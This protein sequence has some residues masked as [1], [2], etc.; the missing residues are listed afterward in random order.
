MKIIKSLFLAVAVFQAFGLTAQ[1][2]I[3]L[4]AGINLA[5]V[6][7]SPAFEIPDIELQ[8]IT[9][10]NFAAFAEFGLTDRFALQ[11][12][13]NFLQKGVEMKAKAIENQPDFKLKMVVN[14]LEVPV[15]GKFLFGSD[16]LKG[17]VL[18]GPSI[19]YAL[20]GKTTLTSDGMTEKEKIE[21]DKDYDADGVKDQRWDFSAVLGA[22]GALGAGPGNVI[23]DFRY[24]LDFTDFSK[25]KN[26]APAGYEKSYNR[27]L[28]IS[29]GYQ[30]PIVK[31]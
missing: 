14:Y 30:I 1:T 22:G 8:S 13:V 26:S 9:G 16:K 24:G 25:F 15:L 31:A 6:S 7:E 29:L 18:A 27:G 5:K 2:N 10:L 28:G 3:G 4:R 17:F 19:G 12:E 23:L 21:F 11:P 20:G